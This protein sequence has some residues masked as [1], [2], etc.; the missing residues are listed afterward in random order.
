MLLVISLLV[1]TGVIFLVRKHKATLDFLQKLGFDFTNTSEEML[2]TMRLGLYY[3]FN[4]ADDTGENP[5]DFE[6][7]VAGI[8]EDLHGGQA[9][10]TKRSHDFGVDIEHNRPDGFYVGQVKCYN[11]PV[12][13]EP[14]AII[15]SQ[16]V[17]QKAQGGVVVTTSSFTDGAKQY[18]TGLGIELIDGKALV[19]YWLK[20]H[21]AK[22]NLVRTYQVEPAE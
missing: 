1:V 20:A 7:F 16:M 18:A 21:S 19:S 11:K 22:W 15:H 17:K 10:V 8:L 4:N 3:R 12:G 5:F 6:G 13:Y 9:I 14:I 2:E